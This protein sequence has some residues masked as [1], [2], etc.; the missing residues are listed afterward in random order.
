M[1]ILAS[2]WCER[3]NEGMRRF[4]SSSLVCVV[5]VACGGANTTD[6]FGG[7]SDGG[8]GGGT[9]D[10]G[11]TADGSGG[12]GGGSD[13]G[14]GGGGGTD[15]GGGGGKVDSGTL[16]DGGSNTP[17]TV[18]A[19]G[20]GHSC[21]SGEVCVSNNCM[22][23]VCQKVI[24]QAMDFNPV[25]G[26]DAV[27]YWNASTA[28][29]FIAAVKSSGVCATPAQCNGAPAG[30]AKCGVVA[31]ADCAFERPDL[32]GN[33]C[34]VSAKNPSCWGMPQNC[35]KVT[36]GVTQCVGGGCIELCDAIK[37]QT[38]FRVTAVACKIM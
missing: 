31:A 25:C 23:G 22:T 38:P 4:A 1:R 35:P 36:Q 28:A 29:D 14:G 16:K 27:N 19:G 15:G 33:A 30:N 13:G 11:S 21:S 24:P 8:S 37:N 3:H 32:G 6:L 17:C 5:L 7:D 20:V 9:V 10:G 34:G 18:D 26:C 2:L 12:G